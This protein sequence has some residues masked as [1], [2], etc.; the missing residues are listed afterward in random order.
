MAGHDI[1]NK[2]EGNIKF[3]ETRIAKARKT[4]G[5]KD[6][7]LSLDIYNSNEQKDMLNDLDRKVIEHCERNC[8][9]D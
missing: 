4:F 8:V 7:K 9:K 5:K 6:I 1:I 3:I 2:E